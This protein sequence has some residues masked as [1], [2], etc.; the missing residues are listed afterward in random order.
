VTRFIRLFEGDRF[1]K[2]ITSQIFERDFPDR[3]ILEV[4]GVTHFLGEEL[5]KEG[6]AVVDIGEGFLLWGRTTSGQS[7]YNDSAIV[8][9]AERMG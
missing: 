9:I 2:T 8:S 7:P 6:E 3:E 5:A 4:W 1:E